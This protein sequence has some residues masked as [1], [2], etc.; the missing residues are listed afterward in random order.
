MNN[1][2]R[3]PENRAVRQNNHIAYGFV[4][5]FVQPGESALVTN[6]CYQLDGLGENYFLNMFAVNLNLHWRKS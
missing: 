4:I 1:V 6:F 5:L 2:P 3:L